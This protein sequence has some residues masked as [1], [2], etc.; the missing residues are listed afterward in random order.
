MELQSQSTSPCPIPVPPRSS[1]WRICIG[2]FGLM[3]LKYPA[4]LLAALL[5]FCGHGVAL[6]CERERRSTYEAIYAK[7]DRLEREDF[8]RQTQWKKAID[9]SWGQ[10]FPR[11]PIFDSEDSVIELTGRFDLELFLADLCSSQRR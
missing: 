1:V 7:Q 6:R 2:V 4:L 3:A 10:P 5:S 8:E 11:P 9:S